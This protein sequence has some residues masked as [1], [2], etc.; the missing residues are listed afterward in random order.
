VEEGG[1]TQQA[2]LEEGEEGGYIRTAPFPDEKRERIEPKENAE[3]I[4][5]AVHEGGG[6]GGS[7]CPTSLRTS[8]KEKRLSIEGER[9]RDNPRH[10]S[11]KALSRKKNGS[12]GET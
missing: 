1:R 7:V 11:E 5:L 10:I 9:E 3:P 4:A 2:A 12:K 8:K 6:G